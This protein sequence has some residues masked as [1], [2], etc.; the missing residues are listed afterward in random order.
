MDPHRAQ[1]DADRLG[2]WYQ[3]CN[4]DVP[5]VFEEDRDR[6]VYVP[7][8]RFAEQGQGEPCELRGR[9]VAADLR[10]VIRLQRMNGTSWYDVH[11]LYLSQIADLMVPAE[12]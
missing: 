7:L 6:E 9:P 2:A 12:P 11:P 3:A 8:D 1:P 10:A 4:P 5:L